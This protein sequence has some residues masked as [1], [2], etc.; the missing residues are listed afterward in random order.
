MSAAVKKA[1]YMT[2]L[3]GNRLVS[4]SEPRIAF[5]GLIDI[6]EAEVIEA[7]V[8]A[9][10]GARGPVEGGP[11]A[12]EAVEREFTNYLGEIL[13][14]L[15]DI[16]AAEVKETPLKPPFLF[17][18]DEEEIHR[19]SHNAGGKTLQLPSYTQG[20]LAAR[21]NTLRAK[22]REA[23]L[24]AVKVFGPGEGGAEESGDDGSKGAHS[25]SGEGGA[26][27]GSG[28]E[29]EDIIL[30]LNRLS[31]ALWWLFCEFLSRTNRS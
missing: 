27:K 28:A 7:Q 23:E 20:A 11:V 22:V 3:S 9:A 25:G 13:A 21:I 29:R 2:I 17:G 8:L 6:L 5:R 15:R 1:E 31:S 18:M 12:E 26:P 4:K 19:R 30:G 10:G 14:Y 16:M 24:L